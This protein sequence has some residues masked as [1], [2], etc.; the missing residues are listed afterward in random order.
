MREKVGV[1]LHD[2]RPSRRH[3]YDGITLCLPKAVCRSPLPVSNI[4]LFTFASPQ[5]LPPHQDCLGSRV[6]NNAAE[7]INSDN[8]A[9]D[10]DEEED[11]KVSVTR[12]PSPAFLR[13]RDAICAPRSV[14]PPTTWHP[15]HRRASKIRNVLALA[16]DFRQA[17]PQ[18]LYDLVIFEP[19]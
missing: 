11:E 18:C 8:K 6:R 3:W 2:I 7:R 10:G 5:S 14:A 1:T 16:T 17:G 15:I 9:S 19:H 12:L 4:L 13:A